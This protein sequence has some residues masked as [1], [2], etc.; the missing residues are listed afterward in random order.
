MLY[1]SVQVKQDLTKNN[2]VV[3]QLKEQNECCDEE[4]FFYLAQSLLFLRDAFLGR[5][6][7]SPRRAIGRLLRDMRRR[8]SHAFDEIAGDV[9]EGG[10]CSQSR[11]LFT[12]P[13]SPE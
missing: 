3:R 7:R 11:C 2:I 5:G 6:R 13:H 10:N 9:L 8:N 12:T 4:G 1:F